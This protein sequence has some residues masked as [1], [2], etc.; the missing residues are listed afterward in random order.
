MRNHVVSCIGARQR[1]A[2]H[3]HSLVDT[4]VLGRKTARAAAGQ[5]HRVAR[6]QA[7]IGNTGS[8][9]RSRGR[10]VVH[11]IDGADAAQREAF[12][13]HGIAAASGAERI[14][15]AG[16]AAV[17]AA[18]QAQTRGAGE[19]RTAL[20][21]LAGEIGGIPGA[22][23]AEALARHAGCRQGAARHRCGAVIGPCSRQGQIGLVDGGG[24]AGRLV[25]HVVAGIG[26]AQRKTADGNGLASAGIGIGKGGGAGTERNAVAADD[27]GG[28][29]GAAGQGGRRGAIIGFAVG[30][31]TREVDGF[32]RDRG[33]LGVEATDE[34]LV[35]VVADDGGA[36]A[37]GAG[38]GA[39]ARS[40]N[41]SD[42]DGF[43]GA[44]ILVG[45]HALRTGG[46]ERQSGRQGRC[47]SQSRHGRCQGAIV[48]LRGSHAGHI[49]SHVGRQLT[50]VSL[51]VGGKVGRRAIAGRIVKDGK[52]ASTIGQ[53]DKI[54]TR[55]GKF[56]RAC[57]R[58]S[59]I[60]LQ[61]DFPGAVS[62]DAPANRPA[63]GVAC[64]LH[65]GGYFEI[66][67]AIGAQR[68][69][70]V[71][72]FPINTWIVGRIIIRRGTNVIEHDDIAIAGRSGTRHARATGRRPGGLDGHV[73]MIERSRQNTC[74]DIDGVGNTVQPTVKNTVIAYRNIIGIEQ[75]VACHAMGRRCIDGG[76]GIDAQVLAGGFHLA[77]VAGGAAAAC[78]D[79]AVE[80]RGAIRPDRHTAAVASGQSIG[81][82][83]GACCNCRGVRILLGAGAEE[84]S[85]DEC[86][87]AA[88][89][90]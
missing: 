57:T 25:D 34:V 6:N 21:I 22:G 70:V 18:A 2:A 51:Q 77:A 12:G 35:A 85:A 89:V 3:R 27:T 74:V 39:G 68:E 4:G 17:A 11:F 33:S 28:D 75:P 16:Q 54:L 61:Y 37:G 38:D 52:G 64:I 87:A 48:S 84:I 88:G 46:I 83:R 86:G 45:K 44:D 60:C 47:G 67:V 40:G 41:A 73:A 71:T 56:D 19:R 62:Q 69:R 49:D 30:S 8:V 32:G 59:I 23:N 36:I 14:V 43:V 29:T 50:G 31:H 78:R 55:I 58:G 13:S 79:A 15:I 65:V 5:R 7:R 42:S 80:L 9:E 20:H 66:N 81:L 24:Q 76:A 90:A 53:Q 1:V 10:G 63:G 26:A 82:D 72:H